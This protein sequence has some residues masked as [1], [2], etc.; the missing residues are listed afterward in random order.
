MKKINFPYIAL[1]LG[2]VLMLVVIKGSEVRGGEAATAIP[3]LSLLV[4]NEFAFFVTAIGAYIGIR[5]IVST[6]I[7]PVYTITIVFCVLLSIRFL[8]LGIDLWPL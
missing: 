6:G 5:Q 3:L 1:G 2:L 4:I 7:K 8:M